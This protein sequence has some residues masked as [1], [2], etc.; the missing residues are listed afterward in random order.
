MK[1]I[2]YILIIF[3]C[4]SCK[5]EAD[6]KEFSI[7]TNLENAIHTI[8][9]VDAFEL[10]KDAISTKDTT[11]LNNIFTFPI[12]DPECIAAAYMFENDKSIVSLGKNDFYKRYDN[13]FPNTFIH[14][15][16]KV[17]ANELEKLGEITTEKTTT[18][19]N[20]YY[21]NIKYYN[22][23]NMLTISLYNM[24]EEAD[25]DVEQC[26]IYTFSMDSLQFIKLQIAG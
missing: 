13:L 10:L 19:N 18:G 16:A 20:T 21:S 11:I 25:M 24:Y 2:I 14:S 22:N 23:N 17:D 5:R 6:N 26:Y 9:F 8:S 3:I 7:D 15:I 4:I 12:T 1:Y